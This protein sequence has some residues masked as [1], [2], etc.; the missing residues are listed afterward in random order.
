MKHYQHV[1]EGHN[2]LE[3]NQNAAL[4]SKGR[5]HKVDVKCE[6]VLCCLDHWTGLCTEL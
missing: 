3:V 2:L 6:G 5:V 1:G 4:E